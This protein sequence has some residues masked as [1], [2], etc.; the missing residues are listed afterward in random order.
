MC[1]A[2]QSGKQTCLFS[3]KYNLQKVAAFGKAKIFEALLSISLLQVVH[4][5][6][7]M[8]LIYFFIHSIYKKFGGR[9]RIRNIRTF[10]TGSDLF[11]TGTIHSITR[12]TI[13]TL[14][15]IKS[16]VLLNTDGAFQGGREEGS[17]TMDRVLEDAQVSV[18]QYCVYKVQLTLLYYYLCQDKMDVICFP[19]MLGIGRRMQCRLG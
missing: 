8:C 9:H 13:H 12:L 1:S 15:F 18:I 5:C 2:Y 7:V 17:A 19:P 3:Y 14:P 6:L 16:N 10:Q 4:L 11:G